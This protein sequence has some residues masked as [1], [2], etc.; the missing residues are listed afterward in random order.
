MWVIEE[1]EFYTVARETVH[2]VSSERRNSRSRNLAGEKKTTFF[3]ATEE[4][5]QVNC[6]QVGRSGVTGGKYGKQRLCKVC[7]GRH[8]I[9]ACD[10]FRNMD[11][12][13]RW[14]VAKHFKLC[15]R[16]LGDDHSGNQCT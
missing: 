12:R 13:Q 16:C 2:G 7:N 5:Q 1:S 9:W 14:N 15:F 11:I 4:L 8:G 3:G 6:F 10:A